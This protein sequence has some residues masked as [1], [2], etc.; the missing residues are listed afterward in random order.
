MNTIGATIKKLRGAK[1]LTQEE[2]AEATATILANK[3][4]ITVNYC[5]DRKVPDSRGRNIC[6]HTLE[7]GERIVIVDDLINSGKT[8]SDRIEKLREIADIKVVALV[9][10]V[11]RGDGA[12]FMKEKYDAKTLTVI[13]GDDITSAI[14]RGI[15]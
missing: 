4:G 6:G 5:S 1:G 8:V 10:I 3:Y 11:D 15:V 14:E 13:T 2:L 9:A 7:D 12:K